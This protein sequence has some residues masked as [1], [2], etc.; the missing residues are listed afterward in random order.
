[1]T[2]ASPLDLSSIPLDE[3]QRELGASRDGLSPT[4]AADRLVRC[5]PNEIA[6]KRRQPLLEFASYFWAPI[7]WMIEV[8]LALSLVTRHWTDAA[9]IGVLLAMNGL[10]PTRRS[11]KPRTRSRRSSKGS[12][13]RLAYDVAATGCRC[14]SEIWCP[15]MW[16]GSALVMSSLPTPGY[17]MTHSSR[18]TNLR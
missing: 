18:S 14:R 9:I 13:L 10:W 8:A 1:M 5:G 3:L 15:V 6:E 16:C 4:E 7:P 17:S 12:R 11:M 2:V